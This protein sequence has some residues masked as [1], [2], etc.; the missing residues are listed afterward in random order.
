M[1][2]RHIKNIFSI[3]NSAVKRDMWIKDQ[4]QS[5]DKD[6]LILDAGCG[7]QRYKSFCEHLKYK[8]QDFNQ[9]DGK[10]DGTGLQNCDWKYGTLDYV[11]N[12]WEI[13]EESSFFDVILCT[14]VLEHIPFPNKTIEEFSRLIKP[15]GK[16]ILTA[17]F[18]SIP[19]MSPYYYYN[20]F[21]I[22]WYE[23]AAKQNNLEIVC[24]EANGN[25]FSFV[26]QEL[27]RTTHHVQNKVLKFIFKSIVHLFIPFLKLLSKIDK[28]TASYLNSGYHVIMVKK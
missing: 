12:I 6:S 27:I 14:E 15:G 24:I 3:E 1:F 16:I 23:Q 20:G 19:H 13:N 21:S 5:I 25:A 22:Y 7:P 17:P 4:L 8:S 28:K 11:G 2:I 9:Y 18:C 26:G 10:G